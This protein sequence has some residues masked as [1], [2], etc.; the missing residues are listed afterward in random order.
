MW[1]KIRFVLTLLYAR[2]LKKNIPVCVGLHVTN[3]C[4]FNCIYCYGNYPEKHEEEIKTPQILR[5]I[6]ELSAMGTSWLTISGG[7]PL[8]RED[9]EL[10][11]DEIKKQKLICSINTNASLIEK[12]IEVVKK[13]DYITLSIDGDEAAN[14]ANRGS[15]T[16]KSIM[17]GIDCLQKNNISFDA[18]AVITKNNVG[19]IETLLE[20]A[21]EKGFCIEFNFLQ[22]QDVKEQD[23]SNFVLSDEEI[24]ETL[25][26]LIQYKKE[27]RPIFYALSSR[28]YAL[29][30]PVSYQEKILFR[31][32]DGFSPMECSMGKLMC[33]I[34]VDGKVYP[35]IQLAGKFPALSYAE[36]G[37]KKAWENLAEK[38][39][40]RSCYAVCY[41]EFN[42]ILS[43]TPKVWMNTVSQMI[44]NN[45]Y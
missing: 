24:K 4:N 41:A 40:C 31:D 25:K 16:Y 28:Q 12:K 8:L 32:V 26:K 34:D 43:L 35:C 13:I 42:Q 10:I 44:R 30:W 38:R 17:K 33:H 27:G 5:L 23:H 19:S 9:I 39:N 37:F 29:D 20:L 36:H 3:R 1:K 7:E 14:D 45:F 21:E 22:D 11:V 18:V 15:G 6:G 2:I